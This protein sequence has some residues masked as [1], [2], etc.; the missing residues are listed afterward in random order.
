M[1]GAIEMIQKKEILGLEFL[2]VVP[3]MVSIRIRQG[4]KLA[5]S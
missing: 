1:D 4:N 5:R 2:G 3:T